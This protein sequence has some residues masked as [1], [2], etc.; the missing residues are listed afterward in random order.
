MEPDPAYTSAQLTKSPTF[1]DNLKFIHIFKHYSIGR[2]S[3]AVL[4][5]NNGNSADGT[6]AIDALHKSE[7]ML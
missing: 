6:E 1:T 5:P 2:T 4:V 7:Q 3:V